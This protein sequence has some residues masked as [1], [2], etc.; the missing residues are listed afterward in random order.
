MRTG[1]GAGISVWGLSCFRGH[2]CGVALEKL[3]STGLYADL[4]EMDSDTVPEG[5][6]ISTKPEAGK[7]SEFGKY[8]TVYVSNGQGETSGETTESDTAEE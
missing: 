2:L 7:E 1:S 6:V 8:V 3:E 4:R 5:I